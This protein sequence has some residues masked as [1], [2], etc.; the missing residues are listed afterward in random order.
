MEPRPLFDLLREAEAQRDTARAEV[1]RLLDAVLEA[2][3]QLDHPAS[4]AGHARAILFDALRGEHHGDLPLQRAA[5]QLVAAIEARDAIAA[6]LEVK[7]QKLE[8]SEIERAGLPPLHG[9][10]PAKVLAALR[11]LVQDIESQCH[12]HPLETLPSFAEAR[13][14]ATG[15]ESNETTPAPTSGSPAAI[16]EATGR[17]AAAVQSLAAAA[18]QLTLVH[19]ADDYRSRVDFARREA[20]KARDLVLAAGL[21]QS[22]VAPSYPDDC[23]F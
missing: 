11:A 13:A 20:V 4:D 15:N 22:R 9:P 7:A 21:P 12:I 1:E 18:A 8:A 16:A 23:P 2:H 19:G 14:W 10:D 5:L 3:G 17:L 6:E